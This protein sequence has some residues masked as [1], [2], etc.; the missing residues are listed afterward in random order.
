MRVYFPDLKTLSCKSFILCAE[1]KWHTDPCKGRRIEG[2]DSD[3][4]LSVLPTCAVDG[5]NM[6]SHLACGLL[7]TVPEQ[8][9]SC[10]SCNKSSR[11]RL[12]LKDFFVESGE[13]TE[14]SS[15]FSRTSFQTRENLQW[16]L[17][18][19][20]DALRLQSWFNLFP[21]I[22]EYVLVSYSVNSHM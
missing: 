3:R 17:R 13:A 8:F 19:R 15:F 4:A 9:D 11:L 18:M 2:G 7:S 10:A 20:V 16:Y 21:S 22:S 1:P 14:M 6:R 12:Q 5:R